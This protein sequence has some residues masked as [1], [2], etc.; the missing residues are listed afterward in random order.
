MPDRVGM[1]RRRECRKCGKRFTTHEKVVSLD[2]KIIK[3][4][5]RVEDYAREKITKG[6]RK[7]CWKRDVLQNE[8][9]N[10]I[11]DVELRLLNRKRTKIKS[12][13]IGKMILTRLKKVDDVA[14]L[15]F[16]SVY[17]DFEKADD[18]KLVLSDLKLKRSKKKKRKNN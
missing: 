10:L 1:R 7:A 4:D 14:Y 5:G 3:K 2:L 11:D 12:R 18:F 16:A 6:I 17:M 13:G 8:I 9:E 15:R